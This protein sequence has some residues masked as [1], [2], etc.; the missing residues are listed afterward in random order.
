MLTSVWSMCPNGMATVA[1]ARR[2]FGGWLGVFAVVLVSVLVLVLMLAL[3]LVLVLVLAV[4]AVVATIATTAQA[5][6][7]DQ[8]RVPAGCLWVG[9]ACVF[10]AQ[11]W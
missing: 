1:D 2:C 11:S 9:M 8:R 3:V 4:A 5:A 6:A 7:Q 10:I